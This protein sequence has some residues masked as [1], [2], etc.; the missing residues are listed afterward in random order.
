[1]LNNIAIQ[2]DVLEIS[3][4]FT[5]FYLGFINLMEKVH[6]LIYNVKYI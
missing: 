3:P 4:R 1:M 5:E 2:L 6:I